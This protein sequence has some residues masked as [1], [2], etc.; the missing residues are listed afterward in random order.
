MI[1]LK[2]ANIEKFQTLF[3]KELHQEQKYL[4]I[5][6]KLV[7]LLNDIN[8][9]MSWI[10]QNIKFRQKIALDVNLQIHKNYVSQ[11]ES[12]N[13]DLL[14]FNETHKA[15]LD[16]FQ[17]DKIADLQKINIEQ[18]QI[19]KAF[20]ES[21]DKLKIQYEEKLKQ[22][23][24]QLKREHSQFEK[25]KLR[26]RKTYQDISKEIE[27]EKKETVFNLEKKYASIINEVN[28][29]LETYHIDREKALEEND[30]LTQSNKEE[31]DKVYLSIK[32]N[33]H[34]LTTQFNQA[35]NKLKKAHEK[36]KNQLE[37]EHKR[38]IEPVTHRLE[39]L[40]L[41]YQE[42]I[43]KA[44][45]QYQANLLH[46]D[47]EFNHQKSRYEDKKAKIIHT[48]NE[49]ITLLNSK[50]SAF[51][52]SIAKDKIE[53]S[54]ALRD[55]I[56]QADSIKLKDKINRDLTNVLRALD[57][58]LNKQIL[59]TQKDIV[60]KQKDLQHDLYNHDLKHLVEMNEWRLQR[61][62]LSYQYKQELAKV[63]LNFN[64]NLSLSKKHLALLEET[65]KYQLHV[66]NITL[67]KD[68]LQLETQ[69]QVQA[70]VQERELNL[71]NNDQ[72]LSN[73]LAKYEAANINYKYQIM[74]EEETLKELKAKLDYESET[75]VV[76]VT[77]QLELEKVRSKRDFTQSEQD[78]RSE[79]AVALFEKNKHHILKEYNQGLQ[80]ISQKERVNQIE[81][82]YQI[83]KI[84]LDQQKKH[85]NQEYLSLEK[86]SIHQTELS[87]EK[88]L[89]LMKL[90]LNEL[91]DQQ[92]KSE[93]MFY[94][95]RMFYSKHQYIKSII[96]ELYLLP[97]HP[98]VFKQ[99]LNYFL[100]LETSLQEGITQIVTYFKTLDHQ[101]YQKK[102][103]DQTE[104]KYM[105]KHED[106]MNLFEQE[107][108]KIKS[109][110]KDIHKDIE[111]L[112]QQ[113]FIEQQNLERQTQFITQLEKINESI[114]SGLIP[115]KS[116]H[117]DIKDNK[118]LIQNHE[119]EI[120]SIK[121]KL[122]HIEKAIDK[123]HL[124]LMPFEKQ[125]S[126]INDN[127]LREQAI[128]KKHQQKESNFYEVSQSNNQKI[129]DQLLSDLIHF[130]NHH[131]AYIK[132][133]EDTVY[134]TDLQLV[135]EE[136]KLT[137]A[138]RIFEQK[139]IRHQQALLN[140][141][142]D[143]YQENDEKQNDIISDFDSS[144]AH[145]INGLKKN[146]QLVLDQIDSF[147]KKNN[148]H[149]EKDI[150]SQEEFF[151]TDQA[152]KASEL[153]KKFNYVQQNIKLLEDKLQEH[154]S[155][156]KQEL[157]SI[158]DNQVQIANQSYQEYHKKMDV[159]NLNYQKHLD[160]YKTTL[161]QEE[162]TYTNFVQSTENKN[163][164]L[165]SRF[166]QNRIKQLESHK[167]RNEHY[168]QDISKSKTAQDKREKA[169]EQEISSM[170]ENR[171]YEIKNM[172]EH[173]KKYNLKLE[174]AQHKVLRGEQ[175]SLRKNFRFKLK[176]LHL[177]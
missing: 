93:F 141:M 29:N 165:L 63:D 166:E 109:Q 24:T 100:S 21:K 35:I 169:Y 25:E 13:S 42:T 53:Q 41:E 75:Q 133:L 76:Q 96:K 48:S 97:S 145:W 113:F 147:A 126:Q 128:L 154:L 170:Q 151:K 175:R 172:N 89:R 150:K 138:Q 50:L 167:Q 83:E 71:L 56:K 34:L 49:T 85:H 153:E 123:K 77:S 161:D 72:H 17:K 134:V 98:E 158:N 65:Y 94:A 115:S 64:H 130:T 129:Y 164:T 112:E 37:A 80:E 140:H 67:K 47:D 117:K 176:Q 110:E 116:K 162:K 28:Q 155:F 120:K 124:K 60:V 15:R 131:I 137:R 142:H 4:P 132:T 102:I 92:K 84:K 104:Y 87:H 40:N 156:M 139:L 26:S 118:S 31:N 6:K 18:K 95:L 16:Q 146:N 38:K 159:L 3:S 32:N 90:Y 23:E 91:N 19:I 82:K 173:I 5:S 10:D 59:R 171:S 88:A 14:A 111:S 66:L 61:N 114:S 79:I 101:Y 81:K 46:L 68:L 1:I 149:K 55:E 30:K 62:L 148:L 33:Y 70:H 74:I 69:L 168:D 36:A 22:F 52:E 8:P 125:I 160:K 144:Q 78:I 143:F 45:K 11:I 20:E 103:D 73:Y 27:D 174:R 135:Q 51:R 105:L 99:M 54:R 39:Q 9:T 108:E 122:S 57:N 119:K 136:K 43:D 163:Q 58:D 127:M 7:V 177:K 157:K 107:L 2:I 152:V 121:H 86:K 106:S 12:L 44:K